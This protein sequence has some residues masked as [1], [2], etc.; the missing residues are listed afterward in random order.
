MN[1]SL[2][3]REDIRHVEMNE[4]SQRIH[5]MVDEYET[6]LWFRHPE[7]PRLRQGQTMA[8][9]VEKSKDIFIEKVSSGEFHEGAMRSMEREF[10]LLNLRLAYLIL[11]LRARKEVVLVPS[12]R[13]YLYL[14]K[15]LLVGT[16][17][18]LINY[19]NLEDEG[20]SNNLLKLLTDISE[21]AGE[22]CESILEFRIV[23]ILIMFLTLFTADKQTIS[24]LSQLL[25]TQEHIA[26]GH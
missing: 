20:T 5:S 2:E 26:Y 14:G 25:L 6:L 23:N 12:K 10:N 16:L 3:N 22:D 7:N 1:S 8:D 21:K 15:P 11:D 9:K 13:G 24:F 4:Y 19:E 17:E 18:N